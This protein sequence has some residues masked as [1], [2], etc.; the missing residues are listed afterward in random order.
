MVDFHPIAHDSDSAPV[1][2]KFI[3]NHYNFMSPFYQVHSQLVSVSFD[4][5][6][7]GRT[8]ISCQTDAVFRFTVFFIQ[9]FEE[10]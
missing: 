6:P 5:A 1:P 8:K 2:S 7:L 3:R 10:I 4:S 9:L